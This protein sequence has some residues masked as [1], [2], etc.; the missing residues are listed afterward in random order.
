M[1]R[2]YIAGKITG[3][4]EDEYKPLFEHA[5]KEVEKLGFEAVCPIDLPHNH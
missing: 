4:S 5:K 3:L 1:K 2:C